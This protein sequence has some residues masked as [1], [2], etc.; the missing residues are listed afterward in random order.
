MGN[1]RMWYYNLLG[2]RCAY[3]GCNLDINDFHIDHV[4]PKSKGGKTPYNTVP[5]CSDCNLFKRDSTLEEFRNRIENIH[6][7]NISTRMM[8]KYYGV[9]KR[10]IKFYFEGVING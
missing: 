10:K 6:S 8:G 3:C 2:G 1:R 7:L 5:S 9:K 4:I